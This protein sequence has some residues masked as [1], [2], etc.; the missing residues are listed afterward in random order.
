VRR[1]TAILRWLRSSWRKLNAE[2]AFVC[3][4]D[5]DEFAS[6]LKSGRKQDLDLLAHKLGKRRNTPRSGTPSAG[7]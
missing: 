2:Q 4:V 7:R 1:L 6:L 3:T 5:P